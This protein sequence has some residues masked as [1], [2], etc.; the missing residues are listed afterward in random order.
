MLGN[1]GNPLSLEFTMKSVWRSASV[2]DFSIQKIRGLVLDWA[3]TTIDYGSLAPVQVFRAV[4]QKIGITVTEAEARGPMGQAKIDHIRSMLQVAR[5]QNE[6][7]AIFGRPSRQED[8]DDLYENFLP[9]QKTVLADHSDVIPGVVEA[10]ASLHQGGLRIASTTGYTRELMDVVEPLAAAQ[11]YAPE[12]TVCSDEVAA[13]RPAPWQVYRAAEKLGIY[14]M[15][16]LAVVDDSI[17]GIQSGL[18]AGCWTIAVAQTGNAMG[19]DRQS[20]ES[21]PKDELEQRLDR[22]AESFIAQG[23]HLVVRSVADLPLI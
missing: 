21:L 11:G 4:F 18:H 10:I 15:N 14:P 5:I 20:C 12:V 1:A 9:L 13:G 8:V 22:I 2:A 6:W 3:G 19:L 17:A 7:Q 16:Q 23:A